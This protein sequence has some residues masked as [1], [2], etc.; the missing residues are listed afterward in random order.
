MVETGMTL[1]GGP[2][3]KRGN[4]YEK[5][6]TVWECLR[7]IGDNTDEIRIEVPGVEKAEFVV[8]VGARRELHQVKCSHPKGK[9][10]VNTLG[11]PKFRLL[12]AI[13]GMLAGNDDRFV[14]VSGSAAPELDALCKAADDAESEE[15]FKR[16][17]LAA[18]GRKQ[19]FE[20]LLGCWRCDV[21]TAIER[22]R[23]ID[24]RT[25]SERELEDKVRL[26]VQ[27]LFLGDPDKVLPEL[28]AIVEDSVHRTLTRRQ[29]VDA[30]AK[31]GYQVRRLSSPEHA[32]SAVETATDRYLDGARRRLIRRTLIPRAT[33]EKLL[34]RLGENATDSA[35]T[36]KAGSGKTALRRPD[37]GSSTRTRL[38]GAV[39]PLRSCPFR[40]NHHRSRAPPRT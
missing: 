11:S 16:D 8:T 17:F 38:A 4:R 3:S 2:A 33:A 35:V 12:Q 6:W 25:I 24:V 32:G 14:F 31:R 26:G 15:E 10:S 29:L 36:G 27:A 1:P 40:I 19:P 30:L 18:Q 22:L 20:T 39:V 37:H 34:S 7:M 23:R 5:L 13:G 28:R 21:P 9:W